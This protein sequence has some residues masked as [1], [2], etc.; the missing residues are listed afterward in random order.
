MFEDELRRIDDIGARAWQYVC[1]G[2][3][4]KAERALKKLEDS[5]CV[6]E[7]TEVVSL[8][9][10]EILARQGKF[11][12]AAEVIKR[13][14]SFLWG[15]PDGLEIMNRANPEVD[16]ESRLFQVKLQG[17][18][19]IWGFTDDNWTMFDVIANSEK[20]ALQW[21]DALGIYRNP[22]K[23]KILASR[24]VEYLGCDLTH[25]GVVRT[26]PFSSVEFG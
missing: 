5:C 16:E 26:Y 24:V 15:R 6:F 19:A 7:S 11:E 14:I 8:V 3:F 22:E 13:H 12:E 9:T 20:E 21:I 17:G 10:A 18:A 25:R 23:R 2:E 1:A 4:G